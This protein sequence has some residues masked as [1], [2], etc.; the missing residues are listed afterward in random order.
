MEITICKSLS[1]FKNNY[2]LPPRPLLRCF[3]KLMVEGSLDLMFHE[4]HSNILV[5]KTLIAPTISNNG[6]ET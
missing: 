1:K 3:G 6:E 5:D 2:L 4:F